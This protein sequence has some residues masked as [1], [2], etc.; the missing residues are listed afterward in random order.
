MRSGRLA[1]IEAYEAVFEALA[2]RGTYKI[3]REMLVAHFR[4]P[5]HV[6]TMRHLAIAVCKVPE[7]RLAN[8]HYG[9]LAARVQRELELAR[10]GYAIEVLATWPE[11]PI[12]ELAEFAFRLR[13][14]VVQAVQRLGWVSDD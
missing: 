8:F 4:M 12:D 3:G 5:R 1:P 7:H 13:P 6:T 11:E 14:E 9:S 10:D 2:R